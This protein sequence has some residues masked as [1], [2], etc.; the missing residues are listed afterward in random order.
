MT[1]QHMKEMEMENLIYEVYAIEDYTSNGN[2]LF[3]KVLLKLI[4]L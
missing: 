1:S 3:W 4:N 2:L